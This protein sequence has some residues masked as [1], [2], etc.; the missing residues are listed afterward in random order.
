M[1]EKRGSRPPYGLPSV[2]PSHAAWYG[3]G[4]KSGLRIRLP[5]SSEVLR[6]LVTD[7]LCSLVFDYHFYHRISLKRQGHFVTRFD[8]AHITGFTVD[9]DF[10]VRLE[11]EAL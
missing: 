8:V 7:L 5:Y 11:C 2:S 4:T 1:A 10:D 3:A 9:F 6:D